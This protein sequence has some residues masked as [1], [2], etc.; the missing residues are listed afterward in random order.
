LLDLAKFLARQGRYE[1]SDRT[2]VQAE[3]VDPD[4]PKILFAKASTYIKT[5][6]NVDAAKELLKQ[7]L[8]A[9]NLTPEDPPKSEAQRLL[10]KASG[11]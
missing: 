11:T 7:Y 1:E 2:F 10:R 4:A 9:S 5:N 8:N 3:R 6:R